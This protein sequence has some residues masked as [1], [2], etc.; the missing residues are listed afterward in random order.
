MHIFQLCFTY[1]LF[2]TYHYVVI[3]DLLCRIFTQILPCVLTSSL[4]YFPDTFMQLNSVYCTL[5]CQRLLHL[6][7]YI[8]IPWYRLVPV[9][10]VPCSCSTD[11]LPC[12]APLVPVTLG[13]RVAA[14]VPA[15]VAPR[16]PAV[17]AR[18]A[19]GASPPTLALQARMRPTR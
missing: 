16:V 13:L 10:F 15:V 7:L 12:P 14:A 4:S 1:N 19:P 6:H 8:L 2:Y 11:T 3:L 17:P 9:I 18:W 5:C